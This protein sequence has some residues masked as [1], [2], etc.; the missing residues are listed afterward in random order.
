MSRK[1]C[2]NKKKNNKKNTKDKSVDE[3]KRFYLILF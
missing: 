2:E 1:M 3:N